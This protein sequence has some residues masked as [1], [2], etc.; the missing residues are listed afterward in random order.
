MIEYPDKAV[1]VITGSI[2]A[3]PLNGI[4]IIE[5]TAEGQDGEFYNIT[6]RAK[7]LFDAGTELSM[8][9]LSW[10]GNI[11]FTDRDNQY[12]E[13]I[14]AQINRQLTIEQRAW[15]IATREADFSGSE[16]K[17]W[18]EYPSTPEEAFQQSTEDATTQTNSPKRVKKTG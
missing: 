12:F 9:G 15:Y 1:E 7:A 3:V 6:Q 18:Q 4:L 13:R 17:M 8:R 14:E 10:L 2:P 5:S 16:E 11:K